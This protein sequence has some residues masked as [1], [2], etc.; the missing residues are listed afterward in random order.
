MT[1][2]R[3]YV[4]AGLL[5]GFGWTVLWAWAADRATGMPIGGA[6]D[7]DHADS[8]TVSDGPTGKR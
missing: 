5:L 2:E 3:L 1:I 4:L 7:A 8:M 6:S